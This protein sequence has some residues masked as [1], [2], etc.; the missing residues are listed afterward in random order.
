MQEIERKFL[1]K[2]EA[3]KALA[4]KQYH[5]IQGFLNSHPERVVRVRLKEDKGYL[6]VKGKSDSS[7]L[8]RFEWETE[9]SLEVVESLLKMCE[10][11][12]IEKIRYEVIIEG[13]TFEVD[14]F[15]GENQGLVIAEIEL[16]DKLETF[17]R[18]TWLGEE[19]TGQTKY[20]NSNLI[21]NPYKNWS[22][23]SEQ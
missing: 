16:Q 21:T 15:Y 22:A 9:I 10:K 18:P 5:I 6:T 8:S 13:K 23:G 11:D 19:V 3:Y 20:Y 1:V 17:K 12:L 2:S 14:E 4:T 7:G